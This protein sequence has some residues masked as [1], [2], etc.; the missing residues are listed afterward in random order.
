MRADGWNR[1][2][3]KQ[4]TGWARRGLALLL[5]AL[6]LFP[7]ASFA[8]G[9]RRVVC[10]GWY[11]T[12]LGEEPA[13]ATGAHGY[14]YTYLQALAQYTGWTYEY[15]PGTWDEC[16]QK[17]AAGEIDMMGFVQKTAERESV[18]GFPK[19]P[20]GI[21]S[22]WLVIGE[23]SRIKNADASSLNGIAVGVVSGNAYN[24]DLERYCAENGVT[25]RTVVYDTLSDISPA[26]KAGEIDAAVVADEDLTADERCL[27]RLA[28]ENQYFVTDIDNPRL[29]RELDEAMMQVNTY[30]PNLASDLYQKYFSMGVED[31]SVFTA[32]EQAFI[33]A[34]PNILVMYDSGWPPV[35]YY[36]EKKQ[37]YAGISPEIFALLSKKCVP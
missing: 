21:S 33:E 31:K 36:D 10:V 19:L 16:L 27:V 15:V 35:E 29:L 2:W 8:E 17:L 32:A 5:A 34:H 26:L 28:S 30:C 22:G 13:D 20:M 3:G 12:G 4:S 37:D 1:K 9:E 24:S 25:V 23:N 11:D 14:D 6:V 7:A 18:Y